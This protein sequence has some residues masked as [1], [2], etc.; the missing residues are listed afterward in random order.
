[1]RMVL[2][3]LAKTAIGEVLSDLVL[4]Y[5]EGGDDVDVAD[6]IPT[7]GG[8]HKAG[9]YFVFGNLAVFVD[10]LDEGGGAV[11]HAD[12]CNV[13]FAH[14]DAPSR[15]RLEPMMYFEC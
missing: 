2:L 1:M 12:D 13:N 10:A 3:G 15:G 11:S 7:D 14:S 8:V 6:L 5:V 4:V 9:D